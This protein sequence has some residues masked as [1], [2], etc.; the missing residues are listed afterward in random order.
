MAMVPSRVP[1]ET[2]Q[3]CRE[4][5]FR[6]MAALHA[7]CVMLGSLTRLQGDE[8]AMRIGEFIMWTLGFRWI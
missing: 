1:G 5:Q 6:S 7:F 8:R 4:L 2:L 3:P